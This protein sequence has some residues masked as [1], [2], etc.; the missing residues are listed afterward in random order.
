MFT[1]N[2]KSIKFPDK[3]DRNKEKKHKNKAGKKAK[4]KKEEKDDKD[5]KDE[6]I[7]HVQFEETPQIL[8]SEPPVQV[9]CN[10]LICYYPLKRL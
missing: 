6:R 8:P 10:L 2:N 5:D 3:K 4:E 7:E 9:S 1:N